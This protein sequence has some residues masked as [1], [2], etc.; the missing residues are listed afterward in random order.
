M[1]KFEVYRRGPLHSAKGKRV[2]SK[3]VEDYKEVGREKIVRSRLVA[4][5][6]YDTFAGT[7]PLKAVR[8]GLALAAVLVGPSG[9]KKM[10][11]VELYDVSVAF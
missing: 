10:M 9:R 7:P 6:S 8:L 5:E 2:K 1:S 11:M 4:M 3:W